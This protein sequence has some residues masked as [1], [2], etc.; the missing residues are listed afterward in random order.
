MAKLKM[1][2]IILV[3]QFIFMKT[4]Y[5]QNNTNLHWKTIIIIIILIIIVINKKTKDTSFECKMKMLTQNTI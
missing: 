2:K 4:L 3:F 5:I 1:R